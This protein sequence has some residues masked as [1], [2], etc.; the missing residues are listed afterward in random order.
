M[1]GRIADIMHIFSNV[2]KMTET[3]KRDRLVEIKV[4]QLRQEKLFDTDQI[5]PADELESMAILQTMFP[6]DSS[7]TNDDFIKRLTDLRNDVHAR[8]VAELEK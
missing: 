1:I 4:N 2:L 5:P 8:A 6:L 7:E 3:E